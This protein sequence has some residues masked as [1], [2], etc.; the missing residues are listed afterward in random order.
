M[1]KITTNGGLVYLSFMLFMYSLVFKTRM[2]SINNI[3]TIRIVTMIIAP[4]AIALTE[5]DL[6]SDS[7]DSTV[8]PDAI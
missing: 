7:T 1:S 6:D 3:A 2:A 4:P 8:A 5:V